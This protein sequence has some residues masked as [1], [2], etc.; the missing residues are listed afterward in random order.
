MATSLGDLGQVHADGGEL[1]RAE[2][3]YQEARAIA[4]DLALPRAEADA[5]GRLALVSLATGTLSA[6]RRRAERGRALSGD[7]GAREPE[8]R[9]LLALGIAA[10]ADGD[11]PE[12]LTCLR[13]AW[14][15]AGETRPGFAPRIRAW[16]GA[17][18]NAAGRDGTGNLALARASGERNV[19]ALCDALEGR[20]SPDLLHA[21]L[22][23]KVRSGR[24]GLP[25]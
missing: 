4:H 18:E 10:L 22:A 6:A 3:C 7:P 8:A 15:R 12:A 9:A 14:Q 13:A 16:L 1:A 17:A 25:E 2:A 5:W 21:R 20:P 24:T 19:V 23:R 11:P